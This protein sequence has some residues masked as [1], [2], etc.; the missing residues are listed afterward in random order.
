MTVTIEDIETAADTI[1]GDVVRTPTVRSPA[2]SQHL[3]CEL[4]LKLESLQLTGSFK[5]RG[6]RN[7][8]GALD[9]AKTAGVIAC[10][11]G[12]HAQGVAYFAGKMD[13]PATIV[14]PLDTPFAKV[15]STE[16]YGARV[17]LEGEG[18]SEAQTHTH[19]IAEREGLT[20]IPPY[21]DDLIIAGQGTAGLEM[22]ADAPNLDTVIIPIGGGG[23]IGGCAVAMKARKPDLRI[24]GV[25]VA[26][27]ATMRAALGG[28]KVEGGGA[29]LAEGI[30][31]KS[32]GERTLPLVRDFVDEIVAVDES[33]IENA[34]ELMADTGRLVVEGAGAAPL[35]VVMEDRDRFTG[36]RTGLLV[37]GGNIDMRVFAS[38]LLRGLVRGGQMVRLRVQI[39]DSPG[40]LARVSRLIG[41][42]GGNIVEIVHQRMFYDVPV[43]HTE[44]DA[45]VETRN[46]AHAAE[47][48]R[49]LTD[50]GLPT[51]LLNDVAGIGSN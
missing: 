36:Q 23:L 11:A 9:R 28:P 41:E 29:T 4:H 16:R 26:S 38:V 40:Q 1:A 51:R 3:G 12:N 19:A 25:E 13:I 20:F 43:K 47:L 27:Y 6:A 21:D 35:A 44:L 15:E 24:I 18:L 50:A 10:S 14:M 2:L 32:P 5:A 48:V 37:S 45:V 33:A 34:V 30:A 7:R 31:V 17:I 49:C 8:L 39:T 42:A 22:I 46:A